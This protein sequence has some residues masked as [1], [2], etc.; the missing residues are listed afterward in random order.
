MKKLLLLLFCCLLTIV[1]PVFAQYDT[2]MPTE[3]D[4]N[5]TTERFPHFH[6]DIEIQPDG[7]VVFTENIT[8]Y[9]A[10]IDIRRGIIRNIPEYRIDKTG[11]KKNIPIKV[12][13]VMLDGKESVFRTETKTP[14]GFR[15]QLIYTNESDKLLEKG[16]HQFTIVYVSRGHVGFFDDFDEIYWNVIGSDCMFSI[17]NISATLY[18][19][20]GSEAI[21]WSCY[22]GAEGSTEQSC[23]CNG[24]KTA[25]FFKA[26]RILLPG[27]GFTIA[28]SFTRDIIQRPTE[29]EERW[30]QTRSSVIGLII[31]LIT[32]IS[33]LFMWVKYGRDAKKQLIVPQFSPPNNWSPAYVRSLY[34]RKFDDKAFTATL[35]QMAVKGSIGIEYRQKDESKK[36]KQYYL[37]PKN[38]DKLTKTEQQ[39]FDDMFDTKKMGNRVDLKERAISFAGSSYLSSAMS[40]LKNNTSTGTLNSDAYYKDNKKYIW[41]GLV[42]CIILWIAHCFVT[43]GD[44]Y[45]SNSIVFVPLTLIMFYQIFRKVMGARTELG[46]RT[47]AE[48]TGL[49]MYLGTAEKHWLN[50]LMP[51]DQ[52]PQHF[53]EMLP[54]AV[55][56]DVENQWCDKFHSVLK[57]Y[58]YT[59]K[60]YSDSDYST[61]ALDGF[62][63]SKVYTSLNNSIV[64]TGVN[65]RGYF[66]SG[67]GSSSS[68]SSSWSSGSSGG[69]YSGGG[70][71][72]GGARGY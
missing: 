16:F 59:P 5:N 13:Q 40:T 17:D 3:A 29:S 36:G 46:A 45:D 24:D 1:V 50:R 30:E 61:N 38:K 20:G 22:T 58:N 65:S 68:G 12:L 26:D 41:I 14:S 23:Y 64:K 63:A 72:G 6:V 25:P 18:L 37:V 47:V 70:G 19:P 7:N 9:A 15:E 27:E 51:P 57:R 54:Y 44:S 34:K 56:L 21:N 55:A 66:G 10:G 42:I 2:F 67:S 71:G 53:E 11:R 52:T 49:R 69:G 4:M 43:D 35:L 48:L 62:F 39:M 31:I 8:V 28:A 60:W 32:G 33:M